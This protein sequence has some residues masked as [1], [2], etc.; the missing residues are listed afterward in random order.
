M[1][2]LP[3]YVFDGWQFD[4]GRLSLSAP[5]GAVIPLTT[6]EMDLLRFFCLNPQRT[7]TREDI[8]RREDGTLLALSERAVDVSIC[9]LRKKIQPGRTHA[10][11]IRCIRNNGYFFA[12]PVTVVM[13]V[14]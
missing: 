4:T 14:G 10:G 3:I 5:N 2:H 9:R 8:R 1:S 7:V 12:A 13:P 6:A 11:L